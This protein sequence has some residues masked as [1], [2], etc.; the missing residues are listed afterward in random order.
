MLKITY[1]GYLVLSPAISS[2]FTV[3]M[4]AA[5]K[6]CEKNLTRPLFWGFRI[7][8]GHRCWRIYKARH[9]CLLW[10][11]ANLYLSATFFTL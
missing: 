2:Q 10:Y 5:A 6:N 7:V 11:A 8:Q 4:C 9:Q 1:A 3:E